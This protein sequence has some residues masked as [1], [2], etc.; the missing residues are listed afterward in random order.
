[1]KTSFFVTAFLI[2]ISPLSL[3]AQNVQTI[4]ADLLKAFKQIDYW[5][6]H[7]TDTIE[8]AATKLGDANDAFAS[9]LKKYTENFPITISAPFNALKKQHLDI[10]TSA[11][12]LFRIYSWDTWQGGTMHDFANVIQFKTGSQTHSVLLTSNDDTYVPYY[13][14]LYT[15]KTGAKTYYLGVYGSIYSSKDAGA[16]IKI[17]AIE[18][19]KLNDGVK[20]IKTQSGLK[21]KIGYNY[22]FSSVAT[23]PYEKRPTITF[24]ETSQSI[25]VPLVDGKGQVTTKFIVYKFDGQYFGKVK[26]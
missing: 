13:S 5:N 1:M 22:D 3:A 10:F 14:N 21:N 24:D 18:N 7:Q 16:G 17:F 11:D 23:I 4:E 8:D 12:G 9:K 20:I 26:G 19:G 6:L 15:F 2:F 25:R